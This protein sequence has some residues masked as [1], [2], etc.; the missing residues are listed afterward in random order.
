MQ[1]C[2]TSVLKNQKLVQNSKVFFLLLPFLLLDGVLIRQPSG[3]GEKNCAFLN[4]VQ[5]STYTVWR[6]QGCAG[7]NKNLVLRVLEVS[8]P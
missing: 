4:S 8:T 2:P 6:K 1:L 7:F 3:D 5:N